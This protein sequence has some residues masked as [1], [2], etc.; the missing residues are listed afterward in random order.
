[1]TIHPKMIERLAQTYISLRNDEK[2]ADQWADQMRAELRP[3]EWQRLIDAVR[4]HAR[5]K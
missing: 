4:E 2:R 5:N 1:M 3:D